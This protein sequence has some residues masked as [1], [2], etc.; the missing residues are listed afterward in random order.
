MARFKWNTQKF[1]NKVDNINSDSM[2]KACELLTNHIKDNMKDGGDPHVPSKPGQ[3][4]AVDT[5][6][7]KGSISYHTSD[8]KS[9]GLTSPA[10][11]SDAVRPPGRQLKGIK[12]G[13]VGTN[14]KYGSFVED[15]TSKMQP[16]PYL[17]PALSGLFTKVLT[18]FR[19]NLRVKLK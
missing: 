3:F 11:G 2:T 18:I 14:T 4:P 13:V 5:A 17:R 19:K 6:K 10:N 9:G 8:G 7:L 1:L 12:V 16:R 15:G